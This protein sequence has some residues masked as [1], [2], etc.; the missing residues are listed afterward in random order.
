MVNASDGLGTTLL[1]VAI[2]AGWVAFA[3]LILRSLGNGIKLLLVKLNK[4]K[5]EPVSS[6]KEKDQK[7]F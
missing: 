4:K 2:A 7:G 1:T 3:V 6:K 5:S